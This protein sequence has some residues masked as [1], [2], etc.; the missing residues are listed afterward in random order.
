MRCQRH[1]VDRRIR[2]AP[3]EGDQPR[4]A[5]AQHA[6]FVGFTHFS[7]GNG[8]VVRLITYALLLKY[9]FNVQTGGRVLNPTAVFCNNREKFYEML[10]DADRGTLLSLDRCCT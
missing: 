3:D 2:R 7:N 5:V 6:H 9:G 8:R 4:H 10:A 1:A